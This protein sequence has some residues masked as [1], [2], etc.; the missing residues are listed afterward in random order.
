MAMEKFHYRLTVG[1]DDDNKPIKERITLPRFG[2]INFGIIR[3]NRKL[4]V[5]EQFFALIEEVATE[6]QLEIMDKADQSEMQ[7]LMQAWQRDA[8]ITEGE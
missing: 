8:E 6:E 3:A 7:K 1:V 5:D 2:A 4:P